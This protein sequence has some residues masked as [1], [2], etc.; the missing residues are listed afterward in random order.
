MVK[1]IFKPKP[2]ETPVHVLESKSSKKQVVNLNPFRFN[3]LPEFK[4]PIEPEKELCVKDLV[5]LENCAYVLNDWY[6]NKNNLF[7]IIG[8]VGCGKTSL[9]ELYCKENSIQLYTVKSSDT[10]KTKKDLLKEIVSFSMYSSTSFFKSK[11]VSKKMI[12]IDEYQNGQS[13]LLG[14]SDILNLLNLKENKQ[15]YKK[16]LTLFLNGVCDFSCD[17]SL[18]PIVIISGDSKGTKLSELKKTQ[19]VFYINEIPFNVLKQWVNTI[20]QLHSDILTEII[21]KCKSDKRLILHTLDFLKKNKISDVTSFIDSFYKDTDSSNF[22]FINVL[23]DNEELNLNDIYKVYEN[24][25]FLLSNLVFE[26]YLDYNQ[27]IHAV[28]K[29]VDSISFGETIFSDTYESNK[30]F[31]P[32]SHCLHALCIPRYYSKDPRLNKNVR[33]CCINNR[34][35][36]YLNNNKILKKINEKNSFDIFD[37][38][39]I[40]KFLNIGLIKTKVLNE[41]QEEFLKNIL[42]SLNEKSLEKMELIYKHFS[43]FYGKE[44]KTKNF[45]LKFKEKIQKIK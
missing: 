23:F 5:G 30:S 34:F 25:G 38:F 22:E 21:K 35:N 1:L 36:I 8:P 39:I 41:S 15:E 7:L 44:T 32:E 29:S 9:I 37:V 13:E 24:D 40:K 18:P 14:I 20:S 3:E 28:A 33:A 2:S 43:D 6:L 4:L 45:T 26:N 42:G 31:L 17:F 27:D 16:E 19:L 11:N 12:L 10:I